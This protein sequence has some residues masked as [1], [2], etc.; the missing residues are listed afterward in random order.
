MSCKFIPTSNYVIFGNCRIDGGCYMPLI[1][2]DNRE[3]MLQVDQDFF[4]LLE[5]SLMKVLGLYNIYEDFSLTSKQWNDVLSEYERITVAD[6]FDSIFEHITNADYTTNSLKNRDM[7]YFINNN[8]KDLW[9][10]IE[11]YKIILSDLKVWS[12]LF[13]KNVEVNVVGL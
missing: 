5:Y 3:H 11:T 2:G 8:G 10:N 1:P 12:D 13:C 7:L 9:D 4:L 6:S